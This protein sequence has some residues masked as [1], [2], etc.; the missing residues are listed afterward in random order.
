[1]S[2]I[3]K[4]LVFEDRVSLAVLDTTALVNEAIARHALSPVAAAALGRTMTAAAYLASWLKDAC[5]AVSVT[6]DGGGPG[7]KVCVTA[8]GALGV[9][10]FIGRPDL[11]LPL[12]GDGK[13]DVGG[14]IGRHGTL[15]VVRD[16]GEGLPFVGTSELVSGEV[17]ED[18]SAYFYTSEQR[19]T[20]I[21]LGVNV[22]P[23]GVCIGAGGVFLQPLPG[24][25]EEVLARTERAIGAFC[26][27]SGRIRDEGA[28]GI[29]QAFGKRADDCS[30]RGIAFRCHCSRERAAA[31]VLAMG[32]REA[33]DIVA[34]D[35]A[36][37]VHCHYCNT[38]YTFDEEDINALFG[39][40]AD[41]GR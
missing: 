36:V 20:A 2:R 41:E 27:C 6:L 12:R 5:S 32:R 4:T 16:D 10:G 25:S 35:G 28:E 7:G 31:A 30:V 34:H 26:R 17:A 37:C 33:E 40:T 3:Y 9:R 22:T 38:D 8:D 29:L 21:A 1:M 23:D 24:A 39:R 19:P 11:S 13:L 18:L 14:C 15:T